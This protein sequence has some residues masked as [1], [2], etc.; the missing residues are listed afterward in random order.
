KNPLI[1][2]AYTI[3]T[4]YI[5]QKVSST[6]DLLSSASTI[7]SKNKISICSYKKCSHP[8]QGS[9]CCWCTGHWRELPNVEE[10]QQ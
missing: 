7:C 5:S 6:Q 3:F 4:K 2:E 8:F 9:I 1:R 10:E